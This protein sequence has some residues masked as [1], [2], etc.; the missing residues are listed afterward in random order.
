MN[1]KEWITILRLN[2]YST[3][4][5]SRDEVI[6]SLVN[7]FKDLGQKNDKEIREWVTNKFVVEKSL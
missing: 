1:E 2:S 7:M 4:G 6:D 5:L 3:S